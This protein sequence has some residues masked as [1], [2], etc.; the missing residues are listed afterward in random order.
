MGPT[1]SGKTGLALELARH[2]PCEIIS[3]DSALVYRDMDIGTAKPSTEELAA[4]PHHLIDVIDPAE[5]YSAARFREDALRLMGEITGRGKL[6]LLVG[7]TM[8]Y[9]RALE[10]GLSDLPEADVR[11]RKALEEQM[12]TQGLEALHHR[13]IE[14]DP[15]SARRIKPTDPQR[16]LRALE[17]YELTGSPMSEHYAKQEKDPL[18]YRV[19]RIALI[20][21]DRGLL[22]QR[23]EQRFDHML[24]QGFVD[25]VRRLYTRGDLD[26][27][28]PAIRAVGYRQ[29]WQYLEGEWDYDTMRHKGI[30]ATR[31]LAKR[32]LTWLRSTES[33]EIYDSEC[34]DREELVDRVRSFLN[35]TDQAS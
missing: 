11:L 17:V 10:Q 1:A 34:L 29:V 12:E 16:I 2:F 27:S 15:E 20:P 35:G 8:L 4:V 24:Q 21:S 6:P 25:E 28:L 30:V 19:L 18:P 3:V 5:S 14:V 13:L 31:Q 26:D 23:I 32:Q 7:G 33:L 9:Y 22:H